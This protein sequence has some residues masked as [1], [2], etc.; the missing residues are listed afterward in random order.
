MIEDTRLTAWETEGEEFLTCTI[1]K[2]D[3]PVDGVIVV[4][5]YRQEEFPF[6]EPCR[7]KIKEDSK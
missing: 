1:C 7:D 4:T 5:G 6:C 2:D 3:F